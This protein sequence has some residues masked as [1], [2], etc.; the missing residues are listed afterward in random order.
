M[1][2][3]G[4][5]CTAAYLCQ[6]ALDGY[7]LKMEL[8]ELQELVSLLRRSSGNLNQIAKRV[9]STGRI[10]DTDIEELLR[11]Q[12]RLWAAANDLLTR[13]TPLK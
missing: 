13:L 9:T 8:P 2:L 4:T 1:E 7:T 10:Y 11:S 3:A 6:M 12:E 5:K